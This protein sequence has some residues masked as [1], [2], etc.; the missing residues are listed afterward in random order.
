MALKYIQKHGG[1]VI[2]LQQEGRGIGLANKVRAYALQDE[3]M[4]TVEANL[5]LGLPEDGREYGVIPDILKDMGIASIQLITNN[6]RKVSRLLGLGVD[7]VGTI[8][9]VVPKANE[10]NI[11]YLETKVKKMDHQ[12]FGDLLEVDERN[13]N[14]KRS[15]VSPMAPKK[16]IIQSQSE[17]C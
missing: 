10:Y 11:R 13:V 7:V 6:P 9:M 5:H 8:P 14:E 16:G 17:S 4:D 2:Y 1:A 15:F 3:G 12:N